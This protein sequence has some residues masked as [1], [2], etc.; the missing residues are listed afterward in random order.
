MSDLLIQIVDEY[1]QPIGQATKQ[2][3]WDKGL[4]HR[5]IR[6]VAV[7]P[8]NKV[9]LQKRSPQ[10]ALFPGCW[11]ETVSGHVDAGESYLEAARREL[12]EE[13]GIQSA[14]L[15][16]VKYYRSSDTF[17]GRELERFNKVYRLNFKT[18]DAEKLTLQK[19]EVQ[20]TQWF[21]LKEIR[22]MIAKDPKNFVLKLQKVIEACF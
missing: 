14:S 22:S 10:L 16:E 5:I 7:S 17:E 21:D 4:I 12:F 13:L 2:Q 18:G 20:K 19:S 8:D 1:D 3:A 11:N 15:K 9:L 6:I